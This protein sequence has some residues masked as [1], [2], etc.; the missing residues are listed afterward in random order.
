[1]GVLCVKW[2]WTGQKVCELLLYASC[3]LFSA[4]ANC[5]ACSEERTGGL[6]SVQI[7]WNTSSKFFCTTLLTLVQ[8]PP[9]IVRLSVWYEY[10][11]NLLLITCFCRYVC[12]WCADVS[13][14]PF[15]SLLS[16]QFY[17]FFFLLL[18]FNQFRKNEVRVKILNKIFVNEKYVLPP[19]QSPWYDLK[20]NLRLVHTSCLSFLWTCVLPMTKLGEIILESPCLSVD[21]PLCSRFFVGTISSEPLKPTLYGRIMS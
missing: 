18:F 11:N 17:I 5:N 9:F 8:C 13:G 2:Q 12:W 6:C 4:R 1:M 16:L 21:L 15:I 20:S 3:W 14:W 10:K 7:Q 19:P